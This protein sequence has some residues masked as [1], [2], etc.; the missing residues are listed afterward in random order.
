[1]NV[2]RECRT[3]KNTHVWRSTFITKRRCLNSLLF[4]PDL[5]LCSDTL[6]NHCTCVLAGQNPAEQIRVFVPTGPKFD[7]QLTLTL[8]QR[9][10]GRTCWAVPSWDPGADIEAFCSHSV[11]IS[12]AHFVQLL[13]YKVSHGEFGESEELWARM[14]EIFRPSVCEIVS[15]KFSFLQC[16]CETLQRCSACT[17]L[18]YCSRKCQVDSSC[19]SEPIKRRHRCCFLRP[20]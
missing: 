4:V 6:Q 3:S 12:K 10:H 2:H 7:C 1:M 19:C 8:V 9:N 17:V 20:C 14:S 5:H 16:R 18:R 11:R 13:F 15:P